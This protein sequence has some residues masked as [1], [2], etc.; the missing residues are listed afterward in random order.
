MPM[1][2]KKTLDAINSKKGFFTFLRAQFSSQISSAFDFVVSILFVN[3]FG[4]TYELSTM[5]G[6]IFGGLLNC[7]IN[8]NWTFKAKGQAVRYVLI[9]FVLVW[10][11]S[12][13]LN[14]YGTVLFTEYAMQYIPVESLPDILVRNVF[15]IPKLIVSIIVGWVWNYNM[16]RVFVYRDH[17]MKGFFKKICPFCSRKKDI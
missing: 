12:I 14:T 3:L 16:Q 4:V 10:F 15:L 1:W 2:F 11:G 9:K 5:L 7:F 8:Y 17:N 13:F 6:N